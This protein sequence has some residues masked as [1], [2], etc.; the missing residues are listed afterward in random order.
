MQAAGVA[1]AYALDDLDS[2]WQA[3]LNELDD[4]LIM[5]VCCL[6]MYLCLRGTLHQFTD[7]V[8]GLDMPLM[9][10]GCSCALQLATVYVQACT[11]S[12]C[13]S[14]MQVLHP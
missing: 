12:H 4:R 5:Q 14:S 3:L 10:C 7:D 1:Q 9:F 13:C 6:W 8:R 11:C 2:D